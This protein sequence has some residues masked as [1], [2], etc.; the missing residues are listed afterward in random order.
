[1]RRSTVS[2]IIDEVCGEL[3]DALANF[4]QLPS[5]KNDWGGISDDFLEFRN[6][7]HCIG[8][9][10]GKHVAMRKPSFSGSLWHNYKGF[11]SMVLLAI[12][13]ARYF[14][15]FV[16]VG[17]Y[18]SNNDSGVLNNSHM[19]K[20]FKRNEVNIPNPGEIEGTDVELSYFLVG[21]EIFPL[22]NS[23]MRPFSGKSLLNEKR[24][25]FNYR[26][27]R[28]HRIIENT[29]GI[30][31]ARWRIFQRPIE[32]IPERVEKYI[33]ATIVLHNYLRQTDNACY[34]PAG[35]FDSVDNT[36]EL[37]EGNWRKLIDN[38]LQPIRPVQNSRYASTAI[39]TRE[40]LTDYFLSER[41]SVSWQWVYIRTEK[42]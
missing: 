16:D 40:K 13:K 33:L 5:V 25:I 21:H 7:P 8:A 41:G 1:M 15:S 42:N 28:A 10:D 4:V 24:K 22:T 17:E 32:G 6:I 38:N 39:E 37:V 3:W 35:F 31:V 19:G 11:F 30:L 23:L 36:G 14:S 20:L 34:T 9:I 27:S 18:G 2:S 26:L 29:F 12:C